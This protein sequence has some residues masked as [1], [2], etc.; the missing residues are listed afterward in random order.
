[1]RRTALLTACALSLA[2]AA[3]AYSQ[4]AA[5]GG[6]TEKPT[7]TAPA[8]PSDKPSQMPGSSGADKGAAA[9]KATTQPG[10]FI[11]QQATNQKMGEKYIGMK[12]EGAQQENI[13]KVT[14]L[15]FDDQ[16]R[17]VGAVLS[18]G[19]FLGI[20]EKRVG[21]AW[22]DLQIQEG[23]TPV[24]K[25][26]LTKDQL[27]SAPDFKTQADLKADQ[28]AERRKTEQPSRPSGGMG[29]GGGSMGGGTTTR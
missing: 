3:P 1:M 12:V 20:G 9:D 21:V 27:K 19:G 7:P 13:G 22:N 4:S 8:A 24:A 14:D 18:V 10:G 16:N 2:L 17:I 11:T 29:G 26:T 28:E 5:P 6:D 15:I 25:V 23:D